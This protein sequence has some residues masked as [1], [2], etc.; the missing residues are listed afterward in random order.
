MKIILNKQAKTISDNITKQIKAVLKQHGIKLKES[1]VM[2]MNF[3]IYTALGGK[4]EK[5]KVDK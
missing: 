2:Q 3:K 1:A 5:F 4:K